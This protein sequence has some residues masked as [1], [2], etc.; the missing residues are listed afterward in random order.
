MSRTTMNQPHLHTLPHTTLFRSV[1]DD[2]TF[3]FVCGREKGDDP[4]EDPRCWVKANPL[5]GVTI[6][7]EYLAG[8]VAQAKA[9]PGKL[10]G[11]LRLHFCKWTDADTAWMTREALAPCLAEF[12]PAI[13]HGK[14]IGEG[15]DLRSEER[16][17][18]KE[19]VSTG[20]S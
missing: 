5:L 15:V 8:V 16:R 4:L 14:K 9:M 20:R 7:D 12:D 10:N 11:I 17:V 3:S 6:T 19:S 1:I 2:T 13:H 18:G